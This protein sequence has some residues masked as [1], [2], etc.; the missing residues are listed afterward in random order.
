MS[1]VAD[2][3]KS[4]LKNLMRGFFPLQIEIEILFLLKRI[5]MKQL[6]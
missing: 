1:S 5:K 6:K 2:F 3:V 4:D